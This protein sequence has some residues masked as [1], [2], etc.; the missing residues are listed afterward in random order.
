MGVVITS[1]L[2]VQIEECRNSSIEKYTGELH[3]E[4]VMDSE[5]LTEI[6]ERVSQLLITQ[7]GEDTGRDNER[8]QR[9]IFFNAEDV[10]CL[11][12]H[13]SDPEKR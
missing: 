12:P 13:T 10:E 9:W 4:R 3:V 7:F 2:L 8:N 5:S 1:P 11:R 6:R